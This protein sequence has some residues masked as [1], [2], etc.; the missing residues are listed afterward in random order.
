MTES[1]T[2]FIL[3]TLDGAYKNFMMGRNQEIVFASWREAMKNQEYEKVHTKMMD[4][5]MTNTMPPT[6]SD[7]VCVDWRKRYDQSN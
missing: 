5:I 7:L 3:K 4:W 2:T 1:E 6:I